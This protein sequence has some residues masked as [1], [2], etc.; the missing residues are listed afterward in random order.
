M[1]T[2]ALP[3]GRMLNH[4]TRLFQR[5]G[6]DA[7]SIEAGDRRL[8]IY[9]ERARFLICRGADVP[10]FVEYGAADVGVAGKDVLWRRAK[11]WPSCWT[12]SWAAVK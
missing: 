8:L 11:T 3:K 7:G 4:L 2:V 12:C 5:A 1:L 9:G 10:T 6:L